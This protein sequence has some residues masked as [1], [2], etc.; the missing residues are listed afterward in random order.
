MECLSL[1]SRLL[2]LLLRGKFLPLLGSL[3][4]AHLCL[5]GLYRLLDLLD[6]LLGEAWRVELLESL[7]DLS[8]ELLEQKLALLLDLLLDGLDFSLLETLSLGHRWRLGWLGGKA[9]AG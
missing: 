1:L 6:L 7:L 3:N 9:A 8:A 2:R 4:R 5:G